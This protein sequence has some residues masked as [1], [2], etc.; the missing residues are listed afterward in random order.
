MLLETVVLRTLAKDRRQRFESMNVVARELR[1]ATHATGRRFSRAGLLFAV[2]TVAALA[3]AFAAWWNVRPSSARVSAPVVTSRTDTPPSA[4]LGSS[5]SPNAQAMSMFLGGR[6]DEHDGATDSSSRAFAEATKLDPYF[7]AAHLRASIGN[8]GYGSG[9]SEEDYAHYRAAFVGRA[10][11][12]EHDRGLLESVEPWFRVPPSLDEVESRLA[13]AASDSPG[14]TDFLV[15][16]CRFRGNIGRGELALHSCK[17]V[18][19]LDPGHALALVFASAISY[20]LGALGTARTLCDQCTALAPFAAACWR[21][22]AKLNASEG[23]CVE[24]ITD[25]RRVIALDPINAWA[26]ATLASALAASGGS[27]ASIVTAYERYETLVREPYE[28]YITASLLST[29]SGDFDAADESLKSWERLV[30]ALRADHMK[31]ILRRIENALEA[32]QPDRVRAV[33][34]EALAR[35]SGWLDAVSDDERIDLW[36][37]LFQAGTLDNI[38]WRKRRDEWL[39]ANLIPKG[40]S[41][42]HSFY[43]WVHAEALGARTANE[44]RRAL[45]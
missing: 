27:R 20:D 13:A 40:A 5:R 22:R 25:T 34:L 19:A 10:T 39:N 6:Q 4:S 41:A 3:V 1:R 2:P 29:W 8:L 11:L 17:A 16:L 44:A 36:R 28:R 35:G 31:P 24:A 33:A 7:G 32:E 37:V 23:R 45:E 43:R 14:D 21:V 26:Y 38:E 18:L 42:S 15:Q 30:G 12:D 9:P